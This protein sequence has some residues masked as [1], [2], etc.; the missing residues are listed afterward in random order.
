LNGV[1]L[2]VAWSVDM[3]SHEN[4]RF[5]HKNQCCSE[6]TQMVSMSAKA[7]RSSFQDLVNDTG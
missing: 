7:I 5:Y 1:G 2:A 4:E 3:R 6:K